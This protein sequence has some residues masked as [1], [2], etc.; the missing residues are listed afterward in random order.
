PYTTLCR[1]NNYLWN[2]MEFLSDDFPNGKG[3]IDEI[4]SMN[5]KIMISIWASF[6]PATKQYRELPKINGLYSFNTWPES[7]LTAWP[8]NMEYPSGVRVYDAFN[9]KARETY[10]NH[11]KDELFELG[12]DASWIDTAVYVQ[13][14]ARREYFD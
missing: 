3:M 7:G 10:L 11:L 4:H 9:P 8:P 2:A 6:G 12:I 13:Q 5:A 14:C 1:S